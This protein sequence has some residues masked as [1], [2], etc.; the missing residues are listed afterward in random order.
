MPRMTGLT[1]QEWKQH[2]QQQADRVGETLGALLASLSPDD[3][4]WI[5]LA[6]P[7]H[8]QAQIAALLPQ[9]RKNPDALPLFGVPFAVK[10]NI[11]VAGLP[12][13]AACPAF[14][15]LADKDA[16]AVAKLKAAGAIVVGKT[17]LDQFATG[18]VG[19]RSPFGVVPN[20][21]N[22]EYIS[23]GSSSG[24]ASVLARGLVAFAL[25][26]DTAGSGRVPAGFNNIV[27]LK[28]TKGWLSA[29]G[30]V[31]ACRL[32]DTISVFALTVED[33]FTVAELAGGYDEADAYSR[34]HPGRSPTALP[35]KPR[36][37]IP[38]D[39]TFFSDAV[40]QAAWQQALVELEATGATL[41]PID[42][43]IFTQLADQLYQG[44]WVAERTV[45]V[46]DMLQQPE[47]MD[48]VVH[49][50]VASGERFSAVEAFK[51]EYLRAELARQIQQTLASFDALV[52]PTSP[53]I[54]SCEAMKQEPVR[55][56]SQLGTYTNFTNLAD[57]SALALPAPFRTDDLPA[58]ITLIAPAWHD[59]A[60]ASFGLR[61]QAQL[62]LTL[63]ATGKTLPAEPA[64]LPPSALHVR[65]AVVGAHLTG[66]PLNH[67]LTRRDAVRVEETRTAENYRLYA[68][69]NTQPAKPGLAKSNDGAAIIVELWDIPLARFG[70]FVAEIPA[71]LGIGTLTLL[72]GRQVKGFICEPAALSDAVDITEFGG[73][74]HWLARQEVS[75]V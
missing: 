13:S 46:G 14:T 51:A 4:A 52:V 16:T 5:A 9:Y 38:S 23:G 63:G 68:L 60:L 7:E 58:G 1:L 32:N 66:M 20:T 74:R 12:T 21:F 41:H 44:P 24:S 22:A 50:I 43:S 36:F 34:C 3:P 48:P 25:G 59:R 47:N 45:A 35:A 61:W 53:T 39:P 73:W 69:A 27:G 72:D 10:D 64:T 8:L 55:Y 15:Y 33:A 37:A 65:L 29:S 19:T 28:P 71:P 11:D 40:A 6:T 18:L 57:L 30:V 49:G 42:F 54:H 70:E 17:N 26:T 67:Q 62:A 31:P 56:N 75:H 2:Y